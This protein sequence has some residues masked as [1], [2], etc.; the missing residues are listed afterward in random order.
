MNPK[1]KSDLIVEAKFDLEGIKARTNSR[2][3]RAL[4][5]LIGNAIDNINL[6]LERFNNLYKLKSEISYNLMQDQNS[7]VY[8]LDKSIIDRDLRQQINR[9]NVALETLLLLQQQDDLSEISN[10]EEISE[11]WLNYFGS[12]A[13]K[14][15]SDN[16]QKM[17]ASILAGEVKRPGSFSLATLRLFAELDQKTADLF[18]SFVKVRFNMQPTVII[19]PENLSGEPLV[20]LTILEEV[21]LLKN[22]IFGTNNNFKKG[23]FQYS[24]NQAIGSL[25]LIADL[26]S[27]VS[28]STIMLTR[29]AEQILN[30]LPPPDELECLE[31]LASQLMPHASRLVIGQ[32]ILIESEKISYN[33]LKIFKESRPPSD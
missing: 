12:H 6:R 11:D 19:R 10:S 24:Y 31:A 7:V 2:I 3:I 9:E 4:D 26:N 17:W 13:E 32:I 23:P 25:I 30:I 29:V 21:G 15:S 27:D 8:E 14:A 28:I 18:Q 33:I 1:D 22:S 5:N 20:N 16:L